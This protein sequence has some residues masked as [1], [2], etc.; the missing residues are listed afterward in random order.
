MTP[1]QAFKSGGRNPNSGLW[2]R[3]WFAF[4]SVFT[5]NPIMHEGE[6]L[7]G[8][9]Q[10]TALDVASGYFM[11]FDMLPEAPD[12]LRAT[13]LIPFM[14]RIFDD[15]GVPSK[16]CVVSHSCWLSSL[17]LELDEDTAEQGEFLEKCGIQ[18]GPMPDLD[19]TEI[20]AWGDSRGIKILYDGDQIF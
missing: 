10:V 4:G 15:F 19:K 20:S 8:I 9:R 6:V 17:E 5:P 12:T 3:E 18:F 2:V 11:G 7:L 16:G 13:R 14:E 1:E